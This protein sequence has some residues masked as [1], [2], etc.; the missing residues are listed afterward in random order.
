MSRAAPEA[1][2]GNRLNVPL[3]VVAI[4]QDAYVALHEI[5]VTRHSMERVVLCFTLFLG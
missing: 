2:L 1:R 4:A 3:Q 5:V